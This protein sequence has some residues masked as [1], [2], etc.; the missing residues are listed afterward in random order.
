MHGRSL[1]GSDWDPAYDHLAEAGRLVEFDI[2]YMSG[3]K[4]T[5]RPGSTLYSAHALLNITGSA[6]SSDGVKLRVMVAG[7]GSQVQCVYMQELM[8]C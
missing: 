5:P 2:T 6:S 4:A 7:L 3:F 8:P 1:Y